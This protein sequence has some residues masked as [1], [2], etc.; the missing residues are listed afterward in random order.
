MIREPAIDSLPRRRVCLIGAGTVS[1]SHADALREIPRARL[2]GICDVDPERARRF[3]EMNALDH[4]FNSIPALIASEACDV[5]HVLVPPGDHLKVAGQLV[6][7]GIGVLLEKPMGCSSEGCRALIDRARAQG[8]ALGV[9]HNAVHF[10]AH[11]NLRR[12]LAARE[13]GPP[14]HFIV[15]V[16]F[17]ASSLPPPAH[18]MLQSPENL[19]LESGVHPLSQIHDLAGAVVSAQTTASGRHELAS[20]MH[21]FDT[22]Q[23]SMLCERATAQLFLSY[24]GSYRRWLEIAVCEDGIMSA[25]VETDCLTATGTTPW[26]SYVDL[27]HRALSLAAQEFVQGVESF[28]RET[29]GAIRPMPRRDPYFL[30][31]RNSIAAFYDSPKNGSAAGNAP[32]AAEVVQM[33]EVL[34]EHIPGRAQAS[35]HS[36]GSRGTGRVDAV[37]LGGTGFIGTA[38]VKQMV[39]RDM[40]VRVMARNPDAADRVF[41]DSR[42]Q[43]CAGDIAD[44][45]AVQRA[46]DGAAAVVHLAH[47]GNFEWDAVQATMIQPAHQLARVCLDRGVDRLVYAGT[48]ASLYLGNAGAVIS[49]ATPT[50]PRLDERGPYAWGKA[51]AEDVLRQSFH[52]HA[53][54]ACIVRPGIVLGSG[55]TP[56]HGG[57]GIWRGAVHCIGWNLGRNPLPL[58]LAADVAAAIML[59][60]EKPAAVGKTY[61]LVGDVRMSARECVEELRRALERPLVF[62]PRL[63]SQHRSVQLSKWLVKQATG[64]AAA[65]PKLRDVRSMGCTAQFDCTD[66]KRDLG[67]QPLCDR[68]EFVREALHVHANG[69]WVD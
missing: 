47:G 21:Y 13:F 45:A 12:R 1:S 3:Q 35:L 11:V 39:G 4:A 30:S 41:S 8:V 31:M 37:V 50:D 18:W 16:N 62:H 19:I 32:A 61:N 6:D 69:A 33:C 40:T 46:I 56:F 64:R 60:L 67:W 53:L 17:P 2:L 43:A 24:G 38:V 15:I 57:F 7:A 25:E 48:I 29:L 34:T 26:G 66:V 58:V 44:P 14:Q 22:W 10:P 63:P 65:F 49:G 27:P 51:R 9:N 42:V 28:R 23:V 20:G 55:G 59:G 52:E 5:A 68:S 54:P 36:A